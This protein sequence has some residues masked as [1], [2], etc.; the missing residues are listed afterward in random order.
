MYFF[1]CWDSTTLSRAASLK[2]S[3]HI[4]FVGMGG[5]PHYQQTPAAGFGEERL[6]DLDRRCEDE[7]ERFLNHDQLQ[8]ERKTGDQKVLAINACT[9]TYV[10]LLSP[11]GK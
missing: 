11:A 7:R 4:D 2:H 5:E 8:A 6:A 1:T 3:S 10:F 9:W